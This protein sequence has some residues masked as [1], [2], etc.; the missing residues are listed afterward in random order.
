MHIKE[1]T[2]RNYRNFGDKPCNLELKPFTLILG[3]NN[4]GKTNLLNAL[5]LIFSQEISA[6]RKR[7]LEIDDINYETVREFKTKVAKT[8]VDVGEIEFP[9][10]KVEALLVGMD[11]DQEAV[12]ADWIVNEGLTEAKI[13]YV[14]GPKGNFPKAEWVEKQRRMLE[15]RGS[16][17][18]EEKIRCIDFPIGE[19]RYSIFG[20]DDSSNECN[21]Y[22]LRMLKMEFLDALRDAQQELVASGGYRLLYR[23]L[24]QSEGG[25]YDDIKR[26]LEGL[27]KAVDENQELKKIKV[28]IEKLLDRVSLEE[29]GGDNKIDFN[30]SSPESAEMLRKISLIYGSSPIDVSRNGLGRNNLLYMCLVLSHLSAKDARGGDTFFRIVGIE[31]PEAHLHPQLEDHLARNIEGI[32]E[33]NKERMQLLLTSHSTHIAAK[34]K[35]ENTVIMFNDRDKGGAENHYVLDGL[36]VNAEKG[37]IHYLSKYLDATKSRMFFARKLVLVEGISEQ[38]LIPRLFH[39][40]FGNEAE[41]YGC[42]ILNVNGVAFSHFLKVVKSGYFI[43]CLVL[44]DKDANKR[45]EERAENLSKKFE[46]GELIKI[47]VTSEGTF[48]KDLI[49]DNVSGDGREILLSVL[50]KT[51]PRSGKAYKDGLGDKDI[52]LEELFSEIENYKS[53]FSFNL[54]GQLAQGG[55]N[56][57][58]PEYIKRGLE[59][60][61][62]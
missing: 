27:E 51:K 33:E 4:V 55:E 1:I 5:G 10:V 30:F 45:T 25:A 46:D 9:E 7:V 23:I 21:M 57:R 24:S 17:S 14:F 44:T 60:I 49:K 6:Y 13:T 2:I 35:L 62:E 36:D 43:K 50:E 8:E 53:E 54:E 29:S 18:L 40:M 34:L 28:Q 3:E 47:E 11:K 37:T 12:V 52:N 22:Y 26:V 31:E 61:V 20:G 58:I 48:E 59:F 16:A 56:F 19:Y 42:E 39:L 15:N 41:K 38:I 32:L